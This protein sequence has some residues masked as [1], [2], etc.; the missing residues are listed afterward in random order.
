MASNKEGA[1]RAGHYWQCGMGG[2]K[3]PAAGLAVVSVPNIIINEAA[4]VAYVSY[5]HGIYKLR[6]LNL[7][8]SLVD[9]TS[10]VLLQ[11]R[12]RQVTLALGPRHK[13]HKEQP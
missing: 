5:K 13:E 2:T 7:L 11:F 4:D 9:L 12:P 1:K 8:S 6:P 3:R 10:C